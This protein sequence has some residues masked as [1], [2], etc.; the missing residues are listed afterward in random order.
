MAGTQFLCFGEYLLYKGSNVYSINSCETIEVF[1]KIREDLDKLKYAVHIT[2]IIMDVTYEN[3]NSY[4]I[5]QLFLNTIYTIAETSKDLDFVTA[6]FKL[7]LLAILGFKPNV[8][9]CSS[10]GQKEK[11][12]YF[13]FQDSGLKCDICGKLDKSSL[14]ISEAAVTA[15]RYV[16]TIEPKQLFSFNISEEAKN[17]L[18]MIANIYTNEKLEKNYKLEELF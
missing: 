11:L 4:K 10:C 14:S 1:Y 13:S 5:L 6:V 16:V 15:I 7:R 18:V 8:A 3:Q 12:S 17:E 2:K 9:S